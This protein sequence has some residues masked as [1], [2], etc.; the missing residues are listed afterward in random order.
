MISL[1]ASSITAALF[2]VAL[3]APSAAA[4]EAAPALPDRDVEQVAYCRDQWFAIEGCRDRAWAG[5][6]VVLGGALGVSAMN[7]HG[8]FAFNDGV[9]SVTNAGP[10][11]SILAGVEFFP[12]LAIEARYVGMYDSA[13]ASVSTAGGQGFLT[14]A[15]I[16]VAR[17]TV[18]LPYVRPY[19]FGGVGYY[20]VAFV[21][22]SGSVLHSSSQ[23]GIPLGSGAFVWRNSWISETMRA[24]RPVFCLRTLPLSSKGSAWGQYSSTTLAASWGVVMEVGGA[25]LAA[26]CSRQRSMSP[27]STAYLYVAVKPATGGGEVVGVRARAS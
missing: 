7:E 11:W 18:P 20:D 24:C 19:L 14:T 21:G 6:E 17:L 8:A 27:S 15:G 12:W 13:K 25:P 10:A 4:Q 9:G 22:A 3:L 5:P 26:L 1:V 23:P 2:A 16:A